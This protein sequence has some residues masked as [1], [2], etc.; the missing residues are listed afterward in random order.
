MNEL[1]DA[2]MK[3]VHVLLISG[4]SALSFSAFAQEAVQDATTEQPVVVVT[5]EDAPDATIAT[6]AAQPASDAAASEPAT[7]E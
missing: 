2:I 7:A 5:Q 1:K 3:L 4:L 6:E